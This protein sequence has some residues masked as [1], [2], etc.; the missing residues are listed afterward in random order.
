MRGKGLTMIA[1]RILKNKTIHI[2]TLKAIHRTLIS[3]STI[4]NM[5][6]MAKEADFKSLIIKYSRYKQNNTDQGDGVEEGFFNSMKRAPELYVLT[7]ILAAITM[8]WW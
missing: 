2:N 5:K 4:N 7:F 6:P 8:R 3:R 1:N